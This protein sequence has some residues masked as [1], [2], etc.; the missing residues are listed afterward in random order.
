MHRITVWIIGLVVA[1]GL[2]P[3]G[4]AVR[5]QGGQPLKPPAVTLKPSLAR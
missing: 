1:V 4:S 5:A 2:F 3:G